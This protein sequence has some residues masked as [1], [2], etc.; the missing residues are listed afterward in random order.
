[1]IRYGPVETLFELA[2]SLR[3]FVPLLAVV[4][5]V[6]TGL[7]IVNWLLLRPRP[8]MRGEQRIGR[9]LV[10][11]V[12]TAIG[13]VLVVLVL[14]VSDATRGQLLGLLGLTLT[15][16]IA[17]SSTTFVANAMAGLMLRV[18]RNIRPGDFVRV[19]D[20]FGRMTERGLFHT[21]IQTEDRD[22]TTLPNLYLV[23]NPVTVVRSSG[24][25]VS[26]TLS[27]G[28]DVHHSAAEKGL[29]E[30][31]VRTRLD[32][33]FVHIVDLGSFSVTYRVAGFLSEAKQILTTRS[34]LRRNVLEVLHG[35]GIEILSPHFMSQRPVSEGHRVLPGEAPRAVRAAGP[36]DHAPEDR[37]FDKAERA[38]A[39]EDLR[40]EHAR[41]TGEI[42]DLSRELAAAAE[43]ARP[44]L[45][46]RIAERTRR[47]DRITAELATG[48]ESAP[49]DA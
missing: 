15:A 22:L 47:R 34:R 13:I 46:R 6:T 44:G 8:D 31:A 12:L 37:I 49:T 38:E 14:P 4:A 39:L 18:V 1:M 20:H 17:L 33:P 19:G 32:E 26:A 21:E 16:M 45:E 48:G 9:Q 36:S 35:A 10:M 40:S 24:T 3:R 25:I 43:S 29:I 11:L 28:Y 42:E 7:G 30:A 27:L 5:A 23:T 2:A 41:L